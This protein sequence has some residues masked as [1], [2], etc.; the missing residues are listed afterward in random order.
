[1]SKLVKLNEELTKYSS[2]RTI[3]TF[4]IDEPVDHVKRVHIV[5]SHGPDMYIEFLAEE[6]KI[7]DGE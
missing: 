3:K 1:M 7:K 4:Y 6:V 2:G 5:F